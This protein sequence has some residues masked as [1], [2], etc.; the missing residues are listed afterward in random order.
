[1]D[2]FSQVSVLLKE[3]GPIDYIDFSPKEPYNFAVTCS[4]RVQ[5]YNP[6]TKVLSKNINKFKES[7]YGGS[8]R[9]DGELICVGGD[10]SVIKIFNVNTRNPLRIFAGHSKPVHR[11]FFTA[12]G[13]RVTSF[14]DDKSS[15]V[16]DIVSEKKL[17]SFSEHHDY[18]R[19]G[20]VSPVSPDIYLS[21]GYDNIVNMYDIRLQK[22]IFSFSHD[23]PVESLLFLPSG[24][25]FLSAGKLYF[26]N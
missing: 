14:S 22:K 12:D 13:T 25:I 21:G 18:V 10:E 4:C 16:W 3:F 7:A 17:I 1:M 15:A 2:I 23:S 26:S 20:C 5:I 8:Y 19:A 24:G 6:V 9:K 11:T